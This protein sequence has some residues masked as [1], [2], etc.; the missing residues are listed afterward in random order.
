MY[1]GSADYMRPLRLALGYNVI[2]RL[3]DNFHE[4]SKL[5]YLN[6]RANMITTFPSVVSY[7]AHVCASEAALIA[8]P[9]SAVRA[10]LSG[11]SRH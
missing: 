9:T 11:N 3:P 10:T 5:R 1:V 2:A 4:L 7:A 6:I 8:C